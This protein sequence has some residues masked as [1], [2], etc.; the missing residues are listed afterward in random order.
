LQHDE[1]VI[2]TVQLRSVDS[3][4]KSAKAAGSGGL[5]EMNQ[6]RN[7]GI[8]AADGDRDARLAMHME[9]IHSQAKRLQRIYGPKRV[10]IVFLDKLNSMGNM[11]LKSLG[12]KQTWDGDAGRNATGV[13]RL[14]KHQAKRRRSMKVMKAMSMKAMSMKVMSMKATKVMKAMPMKAMSTKVMSMKATAM[15]MKA[16]KS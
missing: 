16:K 2:V 13:S 3:W 1:R 15:S 11:I 9:H 12:L 4:L 10:I 6:M 14:F 5:V 8:S 7:L